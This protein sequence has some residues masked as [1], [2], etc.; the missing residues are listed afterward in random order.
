MRKLA[1][2]GVLLLR[3]KEIDPMDGVIRTFTRTIG[4]LEIDYC[5]LEIS[6]LSFESLIW[7]I[8]SIKLDMMTPGEKLILS[9]IKECFD[10]KLHS[11]F[12]QSILNYIGSSKYQV[13]YE[14]G[15]FGF[16]LPKILLNRTSEEAQLTLKGEE[17]VFEDQEKLDENS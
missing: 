13:E 10:I 16:N 11:K 14:R 7:V 4:D 15:S 12:W 3:R 1:A 8:R 5:A 9:R 2:E 17:W 6:Y